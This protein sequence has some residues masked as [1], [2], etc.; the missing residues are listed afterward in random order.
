M[1]PEISNLWKEYKPILKRQIEL[2]KEA[3]KKKS[4]GR[5]NLFNEKI[6]IFLLTALFVFFISF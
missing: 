2:L 3:I 1:K 6:S 4:A 5:V